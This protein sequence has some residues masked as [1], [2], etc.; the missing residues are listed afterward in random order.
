MNDIITR[1]LNSEEPSVRYWTPVEVLGQ[2]PD[3]LG[4]RHARESTRSSPRVARLLSLRGDD[5]RISG[6]PYAKFTGA[7]W[8]LPLLADLGYPPGDPSLLPLRD[9]VYERWLSHEHV[10]ERG[11]VSEAASYQSRSDRVVP[12]LEAPLPR[13][14]YSLAK[15]GR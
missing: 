15:G 12:G 1:L 13:P 10:R 7:H 5:G 14:G 4:V 11:C 6:S 9:Q 2:A 3:S 8:V